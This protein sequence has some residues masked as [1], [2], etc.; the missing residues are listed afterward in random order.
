ME[1]CSTALK[2]GFRSGSGSPS[3]LCVAVPTDGFLERSPTATASTAV[4][5][6]GICGAAARTGGGSPHGVPSAAGAIASVAGA[7]LSVDAGV[8]SPGGGD[9]WSDEEKALLLDALHE[10]GRDWN[11]LQEVLPHR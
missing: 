4:D 9:A 8:A 6:V 5:A 10:V 3:R 7:G 1:S 2:T 11:K